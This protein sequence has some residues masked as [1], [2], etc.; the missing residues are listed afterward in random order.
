LIDK[1]DAFMIP[2]ALCLWA[3]NN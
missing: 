2:A 3:K 1:I